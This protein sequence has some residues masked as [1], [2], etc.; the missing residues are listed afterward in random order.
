MSLCGVL[1]RWTT[2]RPGPDG[3]V[4]T[5]VV[6]HGAGSVAGRFTLDMSFQPVIVIGAARSGTKLLRDCLGTADEF[7]VVPYDINYL[8]R[9][10]NEQFPNDELTPEQLTPK[11][12]T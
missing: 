2:S 5:S 12:T 11:I 6:A 7:A 8:W 10:G 9:L 4:G 3:G 1:S